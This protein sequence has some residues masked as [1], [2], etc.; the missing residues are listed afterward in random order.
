LRPRSIFGFE[1]VLL[2]FRQEAAANALFVPFDA[3]PKN[4]ASQGHKQPAP[5]QE[6]KHLDSL[7]ALPGWCRVVDIQQR[8]LLTPNI[9]P[10]PGATGR[11]Y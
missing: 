2:F 10:T 9:R 8:R 4:E 6:V 5:Y 7:F 1:A 11:C 3:N